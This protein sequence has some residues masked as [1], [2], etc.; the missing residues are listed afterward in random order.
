MEILDQRTAI[1]A[2]GTVDKTGSASEQKTVVR[3]QK[4]VDFET[5]ED[6]C[7]LFLSILKSGELPGG[8]RTIEKLIASDTPSPSQLRSLPRFGALSMTIPN[9]TLDFD[10]LHA[11]I[12]ESEIAMDEMGESSPDFSNA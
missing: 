1:D 2:K 11:R 9:S 6:F 12:R 7:G 3:F 5:F 10:K 8:H 4:G